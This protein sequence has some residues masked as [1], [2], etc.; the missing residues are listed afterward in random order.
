MLDQLEVGLVAGRAEF[1]RADIV[2]DATEAASRR[3]RVIAAA[4]SVTGVQIETEVSAAN[5][6]AFTSTRV[7]VS[8]S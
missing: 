6:V 5:D 8:P 7:I 1:D 3:S 2:D 4:F